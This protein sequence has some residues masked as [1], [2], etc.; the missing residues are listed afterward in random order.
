MNDG[1]WYK[2]NI[3]HDKRRKLEREKEG[4]WGR[5]RTYGEGGGRK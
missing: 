2:A 1:V 4:R 5:K 3:R